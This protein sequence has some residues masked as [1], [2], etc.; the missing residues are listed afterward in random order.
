MLFTYSGS[1]YMAIYSYVAFIVTT[2]V[3]YMYDANNLLV[4]FL[5][6]VH[7]VAPSVHL[8][9]NNQHCIVKHVKLIQLVNLHND[10]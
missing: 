8:M 1:D 7:Y 2:A 3:L 9:D 10:A 6:R 5:L 4:H